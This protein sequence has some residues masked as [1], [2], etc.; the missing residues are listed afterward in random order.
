MKRS[1]STEIEMAS[2]ISTPEVGEDD[3]APLTTPNGSNVLRN[4]GVLDRV[5]SS[6]RQWEKPNLD[7]SSKFYFALPMMGLY[8][9]KYMKISF[10]PKAFS[11]PLTLCMRLSR[12]GVV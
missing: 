4:S 6:V 2:N 3:N 1:A 7:T 10:F 9:M 12:R 11:P 8:A 5:P